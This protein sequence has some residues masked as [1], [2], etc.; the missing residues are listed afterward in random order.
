[1]R[2]KPNQSAGESSEEE[3][4]SEYYV[5]GGGRVGEAVAERLS[6]DGYP[7]SLVDESYDSSG[8]SGTRGDPADVRVL[9]EAG[10]SGASTVVVAT[11]LDRRNF[12][13]AQ[14]V[15]SHFDVSRVLVLANV[16]ERSDSLAEA[17][18][19]TVC[20]TTAL[21]EALVDDL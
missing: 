7:T 10:L 12:L 3:T 4:N 21:S 11:Q 18:H 20:A 2:A 8:L 1:M 17:G 5:L 6:A 19:E 13:I 9:E 14:L 15:R 16:P